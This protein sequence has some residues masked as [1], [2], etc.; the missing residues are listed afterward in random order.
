MPLI[1]Y[2]ISFFMYFITDRI[3]KVS[4]GSQFIDTEYA[5]KISYDYRIP[6]FMRIYLN[7]RLKNQSKNLNVK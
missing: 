6:K 2:F 7:L 1:L 3:T 4:Q 5:F